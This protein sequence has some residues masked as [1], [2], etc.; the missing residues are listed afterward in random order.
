L[1]SAQ[2]NDHTSPR[3]QPILVTYPYTYP[4]SYATGAP[5]QF[6]LEVLAPTPMISAPATFY[7]VNCVRIAYGG[8]TFTDRGLYTCDVG[9]TQ[10]FQQS[11]WMIFSIDPR[12]GTAI[13]HW[14]RP[15]GSTSQTYTAPIG[16]GVTR[17]D[18]TGDSLS[19]TAGDP[20]GEYSD[21]LV[22]TAP[23]REPGLVFSTASVRKGC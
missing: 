22:I 2:A 13:Y 15:D 16:P 10:T 4:L 11:G 7:P 19:L 17:V 18:A 9:G 1:T 5:L 6:Q 21:R 3:T 20:N 14:L 12:P 23:A 8:A